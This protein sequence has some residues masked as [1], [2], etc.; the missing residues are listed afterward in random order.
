MKK[1]YITESQLQMLK[2]KKDEVLFQEFIIGVKS[3]LKDLLKNPGNAKLS[4]IFSANNISKKDLLNKMADL[5]LIKT[6]E[7][8]DEVPI[9]E[10]SKKVAKRFASYKVPRARFKEKME[11][12]FKELFNETVELDTYKI[13]T[14]GY[15]SHVQEIEKPQ[16]F[17][18]SK[19]IV[20]DMINMDDAY[21][22]RGGYDESLVNEDGAAGAGLGGATSCQGVMQAGGTNPNAGTYDTVFGGVQDRDFWKPAMTRGKNKKNKSMAMNRKK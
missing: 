1:I 18:N 11:Q 14:D 8:I 3:F 9:E 4:D 17:K 15:Y 16:V 19:Q 2:E 10:S 6:K 20:S 22:T 21:K 5:G 7:R 13:G 12:L